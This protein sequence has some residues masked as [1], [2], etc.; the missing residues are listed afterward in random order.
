[1]LPLEPFHPPHQ[2]MSCKKCKPGRN[3]CCNE[4]L[5][6]NKILQ[7]G[8]SKGAGVCQKPILTVNCHWEQNEG[9]AENEGLRITKSQHF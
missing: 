7:E 4:N 5:A 1:M 8:D 2:E 3:K 9:L 6:S